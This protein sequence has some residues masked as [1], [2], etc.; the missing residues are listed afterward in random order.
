MPGP[1]AHRSIVLAPELERKIP[2]D[3]ARRWSAPL[4]VAALL[5]LAAL[6]GFQKIRDFDYWWHART[7]QLIAD[8]GSVPHQDVFT[9]SVP[10]NRWIDV[11][12]L[13]QLGLHGL[14]AM[15]GHEAVKG[16]ILENFWLAEQ[17]RAA[18]VP[19]RCRSL[20]GSRASGK[21]VNPVAPVGSARAPSTRNSV[22][23]ARVLGS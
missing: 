11:H 13:F 2:M 15:G 17:L 7:G 23:L 22:P 20:G 10:G 9:Y 5:T 21:L 1:G 16:R 14:R 6:L 12:W 3:F 19:L 8:T 4:V 18:G